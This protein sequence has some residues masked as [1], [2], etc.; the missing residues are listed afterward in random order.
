MGILCLPCKAICN[1]LSS[2][3]WAWGMGVTGIAE[4][5]AKTTAPLFQEAF[6]YGA[7]N[8]AIST[9]VDTVSDNI[10]ERV[11][12][13]DN[14]VADNVWDLT[15]TLLLIVS[16]YGTA[17]LC[18]QTLG[19]KITNSYVHIGTAIKSGFALCGTAW[20]VAAGTTPRIQQERARE[21]L[22]RILGNGGGEDF[23]D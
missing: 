20:A 8:G 7:L 19:T 18:N 6:Y 1:G 12:A 3:I 11:I 23:F 16:R 10:K 13:H 15:K 22:R 14:I 9:I 2:G 4:S 17:Y 21:Q 5:V